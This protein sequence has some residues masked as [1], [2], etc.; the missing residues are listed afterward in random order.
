MTHD[1]AAEILRL[2][3]V[4][5]TGLANDL[6]LHGPIDAPRR[7]V[8]WVTLIPL[9]KTAQAQVTRNGTVL[10]RSYD[11]DFLI[12][13]YGASGVA[14]LEGAV[15]ELDSDTPNAMMALA[16][17]VALRN[18][19]QER[20]DAFRPTVVRTANEPRWDTTL[21]IGY[22][23][24]RTVSEPEAATSVIVDLETASGADYPGAINIGV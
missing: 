14:A 2:Q 7:V 17:G 11:A 16:Q 19:P 1:E 4:A 20:A 21:T 8:G 13:A 24:T 9:A 10:G 3:F 18:A 5:L 6:V 12:T 23:Y 22:V 15:A